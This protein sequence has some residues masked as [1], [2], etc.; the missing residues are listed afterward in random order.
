MQASPAWTIWESQMMEKVE[1]VWLKH[2]CDGNKVVEWEETAIR[3]MP[4]EAI[5]GRIQSNLT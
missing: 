2:L 4:V 3:A 1:L 5:I